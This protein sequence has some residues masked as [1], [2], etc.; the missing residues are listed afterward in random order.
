[1]TSPVRI[2]ERFRDS[3]N[4]SAK[5]SDIYGSFRQAGFAG[6]KSEI[7]CDCVGSGDDGCGLVTRVKLKN[8][9]AGALARGGDL[10]D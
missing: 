9:Q 4:R 10:L 3:S 1:M 7:A 6:A 5:D 8:Q 2:S